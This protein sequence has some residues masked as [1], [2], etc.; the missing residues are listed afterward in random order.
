MAPSYRKKKGINSVKLLKIPGGISEK[1][2]G[3]SEMSASG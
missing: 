3:N 1:M 2:V